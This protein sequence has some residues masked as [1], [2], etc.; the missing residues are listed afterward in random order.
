MKN[1]FC[2]ILAPLVVA[3]L[4]VPIL[5]GCAFLPLL[6]GSAGVSGGGEFSE[7]PFVNSAIYSNDYVVDEGPVKGGSVRI[8]AT[9]PDT[10][11][12]LLTH[13]I[14]TSA[15]YSL[16]FESLAA[17]GPNLTAE[18]M[19]AERWT[20]SV[21]GL[22]W[23][24]VLREG[25]LWHDGRP[26]RAQDVVYTIEHIRSYGASSPYAEMI[27]NIASVTAMSDTEIRM[28]L[29]KENSF[30]P[31]T[32][33]F[34]IVPSHVM[35]DALDGLNGGANL[36]AALIGSGPYRFR[37]YVNGDR[38]V[39][40]ASDTW[41]GADKPEAISPP[42]IKDVSFIFNE[43][44]VMALP[45]Y[46][47]REID[48]FFSKSLNYERYKS[49]SELRIR[50]YSERDFLFV[51]FNCNKGMSSSKSVRRALLRMMDRQRLIS[52][53]L[54]GRGIAAEFPVQPEN[55]I[56][57]EGIVN[58]PHDPQAARSILESAGFRMDNGV[59]YGD[60]GH[61]WNKLSMTLLVNEQDAERCSVADS[62]SH[63]YAESGVEIIVSREPAED[64]MQKLA[65][66]E[67]D[68]A[69]LNYRT[70]LFPDMTELYSTPWQEGKADMNP[71]GY[72]NDEVDNLSHELF[73][74]YDET[75]R[76][77]VFSQLA[78]IIQDD[79]PYIG[80]CFL[81]SVFAHGDGIKGDI[82]PNAWRP[83]GN[84]ERWYISDYK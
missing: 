53:A 55:S 67:F 62:L 40:T 54:E 2:R 1:S 34:P 81:A 36:E 75:D 51:A 39:L 83:L 19:L 71:A 8:Y 56:Y 31:L 43:P 42:Y 22:I 32:W 77:T 64:I 63:M 14:Y 52:E 18:H 59:F 13:N 46:R 78:S 35:I 72:Q 16:V 82:Y 50:Q 26:L 27:S 69:L 57:A 60:V 80:I 58:T 15:M 38:M 61:G 44:A 12:P 49:S 10:F 79:A 48:M 76:M 68:M 6:A 45:L 17:I 66:G 37:N 20:L 41:G 5:S 11:N 21:D 65:E 9:H 47:S 29:I 33:T 74:V 4:L 28:T 3:A 30:A 70:Q 23:H 7:A 84:F 24:I 73:A 25:A